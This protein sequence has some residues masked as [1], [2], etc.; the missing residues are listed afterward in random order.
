MIHNDKASRQ[1]IDM[2][3]LDIVS[4]FFL[5]DLEK[6]L[7]MPGVHFS[8]TSQAGY[9]SKAYKGISMPSFKKKGTKQI[10]NPS[11]RTDF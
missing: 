9:G 7:R 2:T 11:S 3:N 5:F 10:K 6:L 8:E 1:V 4:K